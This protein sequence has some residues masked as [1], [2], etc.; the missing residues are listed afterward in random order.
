MTAQV[1]CK[2][3]TPIDLSS[4][5][6]RQL[7]SCR[8]QL[9]KAQ[10]ENVAALKAALAGATDEASVSLRDEFADYLVKKPA[11]HTFDLTD[12]VKKLD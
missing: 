8:L 11:G 3:K 9:T 4:R 5:L 12:F 7:N 10:R 2:R 6:R 1:K